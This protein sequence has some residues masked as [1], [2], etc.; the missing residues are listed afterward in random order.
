M[1]LQRRALGKYHSG[2]LWTNAC[3]TH[4][5]PGERP[6][7]AARRRLREEIG[8]ACPLKFLARVPIAR[9][10]ATASSRMKS[11]ISSLAITTGRSRRTPRR[12]RRLSGGLTKPWLWTS[13]CNPGITRIGSDTISGIWRE[14]LQG[15]DVGGLTQQG[16]T[17][18]YDYVPVAC[19]LRWRDAGQRCAM[20][21]DSWFSVASPLRSAGE[22]RLVVE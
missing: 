21:Q 15:G 20:A 11:C 7:L 6:D 19:A 12:F 13:N 1:L 16:W 5:R 9:R 10:S 2:G 22:A 14:T 8:I 4:P 3:C 18:M 17:S